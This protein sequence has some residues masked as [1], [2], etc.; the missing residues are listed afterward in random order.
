[1]FASNC[2][3]CSGEHNEESVFLRLRQRQNIDYL[4]IYIYFCITD[5]VVSRN[6]AL[7]YRELEGSSASRDLNKTQLQ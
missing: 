7:C 6:G 4:Y 1:M 5:D 2:D 3:T